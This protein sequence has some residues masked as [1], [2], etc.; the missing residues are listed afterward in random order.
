MIWERKNIIVLRNYFFLKL[1]FQEV[2]RNLSFVE[3]MPPKSHMRGLERVGGSLDL[4]GFWWGSPRL[5]SDVVRGAVGGAPR[6]WKVGGQAA[7]RGAHAEGPNG[8]KS[9]MVGK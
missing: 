3:I 8:C 5:G 2:C 7:G 6:Y 1:F 4:L 9:K